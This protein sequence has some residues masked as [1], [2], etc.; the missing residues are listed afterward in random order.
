[1]VCGCVASRHSTVPSGAGCRG[2]RAADHNAALITNIAMVGIS[3]DVAVGMVSALLAGAALAAAGLIL[4]WQASL[5]AIGAGALALIAQRG[6]RQRSGHFGRAVNI[7]NRD[8]HSHVEQGLA[9]M[10]LARV[11]GREGQQRAGFASAVSNISICKRAAILDAG[12][13]GARRD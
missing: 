13:S 1:M 9:Q 2:E 6:I 4:S 12:I 10:R 8:R 5:V 11:F 3:F 7:A